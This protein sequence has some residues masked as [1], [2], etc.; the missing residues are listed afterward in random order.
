MFCT[1]GVLKNFTK[2]K[3]KYLYLELYQKRDS[4]S[5]ISENTHF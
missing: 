4:R 2:I 3:G 5:E 1:K